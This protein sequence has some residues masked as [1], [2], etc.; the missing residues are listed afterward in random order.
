[1]YSV[2]YARGK[3]HIDG[4]A[5]RPS[6]GGSLSYAVSPCAALSR[7]NRWSTR[8]RT[9]DL[10]EALRVAARTGTGVCAACAA[11]AREVLATV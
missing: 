9:G 6:G 1:M 4:L 5:E 3:A 11:R 2:K 7:S 8:L 10:G